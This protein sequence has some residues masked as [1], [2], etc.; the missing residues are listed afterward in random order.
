[1]N[2][3]PD[4]GVLTDTALEFSTKRLSEQNDGHPAIAGETKLLIVF[5][6]G[7]VILRR[8]S[9]RRGVSPDLRAYRVKI[10]IT[11]GN[12]KESAYLSYAIGLAT[13]HD[14]SGRYVV[15]QPN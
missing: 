13:D 10:G 3:V 4:R 5:E 15:A 8:T 9:R 1:M 7:A 2:F 11:K 12:T 6:R 14:K